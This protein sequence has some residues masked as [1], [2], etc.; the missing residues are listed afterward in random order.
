MRHRHA[1]LE[2]AQR[3]AERARCIALYNDETRPLGE[4]GA[5][6]ADDLANMGVRVFL[7]AAV[8]PNG[9]ERTEAKLPRLK[10][11]MLAGEDQ[12]RLQPARGKRV[13]YRC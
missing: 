7:A 6:C 11:P 5:E 10:S 1:R 8:E 13:R 3:R 4:D 12:A 9:A 2:R